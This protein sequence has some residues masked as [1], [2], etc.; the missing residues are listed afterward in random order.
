MTHTP[1]TLKFGSRC[2]L[3][4]MGVRRESDSLAAAS[5]QFLQLLVRQGEFPNYPVT[6]VCPGRVERAGGREC[7]GGEAGRCVTRSKVFEPQ[8]CKTGAAEPVQLG[9][10]EANVNQP[11]RGSDPSPCSPI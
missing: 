3:G 2:I 5:T 11:K 6:G 9:R 7:V 4:G 10:K 8:P 1:P